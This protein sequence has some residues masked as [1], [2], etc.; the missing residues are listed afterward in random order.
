MQKNIKI[1][2]HDLFLPLGNI[3]LRTFSCEK[4]PKI[5]GE[6]HPSLLRLLILP[7]VVFTYSKCG[8]S[9]L[10]KCYII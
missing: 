3:G 5:I 1:N 10:V 4:D 7:Y 9:E 2:S 6:Y 8:I